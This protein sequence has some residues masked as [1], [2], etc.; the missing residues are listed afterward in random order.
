[1]AD[2]LVRLTVQIPEALHKAAKIAAVKQG[3][4][5]RTLVIEGLAARLKVGA[6]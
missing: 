3:T 1:M 5:L 4:D 6:R 2:K